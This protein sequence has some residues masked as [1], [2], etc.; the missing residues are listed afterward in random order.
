[1]RGAAGM[2]KGNIIKLFEQ[3]SFWRIFI[4]CHWFVGCL[5]LLNSNKMSSSM[6]SGMFGVGGMRMGAGGNNGQG[7]VEFMSDA[8]VSLLWNILSE[9]LNLSSRDSVYIT[10]VRQT[11]E[12]NLDF[13]MRT[14]PIHGAGS[15]ND[16]NKRFMMQLVRALKQ[17]EI[18]PAKSMRQAQ[19]GE[20]VP[21]PFVS[22]GERDRSVLDM[23]FQQRQREYEQMMAPEPPKEVN[24]AYSTEMPVEKITMDQLV[25]RRK[26]QEQTLFSEMDATT[27]GVS[28]PPPEATNRVATR[29]VEFA[30]EDDELKGRTYDV[31]PGAASDALPVPVKAPTAATT[32]APASPPHSDD[33]VSDAFFLKLKPLP[34]ASNA[35]MARAI[36][37]AQLARNEEDMAAIKQEWQEVNEKWRQFSS[38]MAYFSRHFA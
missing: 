15:L 10:N 32:T 36:Q 2:R 6:P 16:Q 12:K 35:A 21:L 7:N 20:E 23:Q 3:C 25:E 37:S 9:E 34:S 17:L 22:V 29:K 30:D 27:G 26:R 19:V 33:E 14:S 13:Y 31:P 4:V 5:Y 8:N 11:F 1:M 24:F 18:I 38:A 28:L